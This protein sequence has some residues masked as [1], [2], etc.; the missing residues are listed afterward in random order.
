MSSPYTA[1]QIADMN[2]QYS[3]RISVPDAERYLENS[4]ALSA[5]ARQTLDGKL[6]IAFGDSDGQKLDIFAAPGANAPVHVFIHGGYWRALDKS[7]YSHVAGPLVSAGAT[8]VIVNYDLCPTV[9]V[10]DIAAQMQRALAWVHTNIASYNGDPTQIH[11]SGH[12]AGAHLGA[13]LIATDWATRFG[14]PND[15]I[16]SSVLLSGLFDITPH[17]FL[18]VQADIRLTEDEAIAMS[19]MGLPAVANSNVLLMVG[20]NEPHLFHWQSLAY[21]ARLRQQGIKAEYVATPGDNHFSITD[22]LAS[23]AD[24][25]TRQLIAHM[26][27]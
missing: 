11:V 26:G 23:A 6:D 3:P 17:R 8:T 18:D 7:F 2:V 10:S 24:P 16:K 21:A 12:S 27:L 13:M 4:A 25:I 5:V 20:E 14:L 1:E 9:R 15:V 19:P 22:R